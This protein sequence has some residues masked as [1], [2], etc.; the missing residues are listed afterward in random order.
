[1]SL[2]PIDP[3]LRTAQTYAP[4]LQGFAGTGRDGRTLRSVPARE[5]GI[6]LNR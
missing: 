3:A 1:M 5:P 2:G 6:G 4:M